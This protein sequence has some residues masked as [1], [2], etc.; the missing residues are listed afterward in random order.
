MTARSWPDSVPVLVDTDRTVLLRPHV[1]GDLPR[2][3][4]QCSDPEFVRWTTTP[5]PYTRAHAQD[6][7]VNQVPTAVDTGRAMFWAIEAPVDGV[8]RFCGSMEIRLGDLGRGEIAFGLHPD[9]RNRGIATAAGRL[10]TDWAFEVAG[11]TVL[12][13]RAVVGNWGSRRVAAALGFRFE[14]VRRRHLPQRGVLRDCWTAALLPDDLRVSVAPP[15]QPALA[16]SGTAPDGPG[17]RQLRLRMPTDADLSRIVAACNDPETRRWLPLLPYPYGPDEAAAYVDACWENAATGRIWTWAVTQ[18][19]DS[20]LGVVSLG[21]LRHPDAQGEIGYWTHPDARGR[22][23]TGAAARLVADFALSPRGPHH[24]LLIKVATGN[25]ASLAV[26][27]RAGAQR[28]GVLPDG[29]QRGD[30]SF[31][32]LVLFSRVAGAGDPL[33]PRS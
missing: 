14:G 9:A 11:R 15:R 21:D 25:H 13:W 29:F 24:S 2:M 30:G 3:V 18:H 26:A 5:H 31:T 20:L 1:S 7:L 6:F 12:E 17:H 33:R 28:V 16:G 27:L 4:E 32:D 19:D 22:G 23:V 8:R 10:A